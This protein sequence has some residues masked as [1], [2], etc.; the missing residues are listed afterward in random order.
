M[1]PS[2]DA[3]GT[4][5]FRSRGVLAVL[6][7]TGQ[8]IVPAYAL[9][10]LT[11]VVDR[12]DT[13]APPYVDL[14]STGA[15][16]AWWFAESGQTMGIVTIATILIVVLVSRPGLSP[17][18]RAVEFGVMAVV[19]IVVLYGGN[20]ANDHLVKPAIGTARPDIEQLA[21]IGELG[22]GV[23]EFYDLSE[24][25]RS[26][27]LD[28]IKDPDGFGVLQMRSEVRDHWVEESAFS[29]PSGHS[30]ASMTFATFYVAV[31]MT[32]LSGWR[33]WTYLLLAPWAVC[34]CLSRAVLRVH[35]PADILLGAAAGIVLGV[36][37]YLV[38]RW[39][40]DRQQPAAVAV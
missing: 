2:P 13:T 10:L 33:R 36:V 21:D 28:R 5:S 25:D 19:S 30:L 22:M 3:D 34:V 23:D 12:L 4:P 20:L 16:V 1:T 32:W 14:T 29:R 31:A 8:W 27:Y 15:L 11:L 40:L 7:R 24:D 37:G 9:L 35:W 38:T 39:L 26:A 6:A 18:W 17:R